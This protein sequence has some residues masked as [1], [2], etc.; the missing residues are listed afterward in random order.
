MHILHN[1]NSH[2]QIYISLLKTKSN[3]F[4]IIYVL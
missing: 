3:V 2:I 1:I 4:S